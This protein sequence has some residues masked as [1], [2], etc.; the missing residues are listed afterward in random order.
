MLMYIVG[1][2]TISLA[3]GHYVNPFYGWLALGVGMILAAV[4]IGMLNY[5][6][7]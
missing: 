4:V 1:L 3:L 5:L 6:G 2:L 7:G